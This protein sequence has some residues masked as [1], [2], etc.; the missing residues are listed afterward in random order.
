MFS[1]C[2]IS[3]YIKMAVG[4]ECL[5]LAENF[6]EMKDEL[7]VNPL[8]SPPRGGGGAYLCQA[9]L[10]GG[11]METGGGLFNIWEGAGGLVNL[12]T[13]MVSVFHKIKLEYKVETLKY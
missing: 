4:K 7:T 6:E 1:G 9:H 13:T 12:A 8:L 10:T 3:L 2:L 11:S 5:G